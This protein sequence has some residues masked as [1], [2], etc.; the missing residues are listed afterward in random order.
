M[1][2]PAV[3]LART[4]GKAAGTAP[5]VYN[6]ANEICVD[7]FCERRLG[8]LG[9]VDTVTAVV[10]EHLAGAANQT[11]LSVDSVLD[12]DAWA[13]RRAAELIGVAG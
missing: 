4:A 5:A 2:F 3:K 9:I 7:A 12:A 10:D 1:A 8:F 6:A 11:P 13:R